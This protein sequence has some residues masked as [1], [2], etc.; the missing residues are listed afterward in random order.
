MLRPPRG[1]N[2][3]L[4]QRIVTED[5]K[6]HLAPRCLIE[7]SAS[8]EADFEGERRNRGRL[9]LITK[10]HIKTQNSW[11]HNIE[12]FVG[13][14]RRTNYLYMHPLDAKQAG[15]AAGDLAD[16]SSET[17]AV[18]VPVKLLAD[19]MPG[20]VALP[21]GWGHQ[22]A[23][24]LTVASAT[25]GVNAN[26]LAADGPEKVERIS[27]MAHLTGIPV[28]VK[29]AAGARESGSWSGMP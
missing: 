27:G 29:P 11:T 6:V 18:R 5:A 25:T 15:L 9:K 1:E 28:E 12:E 8:L 23:A 3:F 19:L 7:A 22:H 21:H 4:G 20:T 2:D 10:R 24:G 14:D 17:A 16:V 26:L 13:P